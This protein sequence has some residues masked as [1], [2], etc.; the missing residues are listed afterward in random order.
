MLFC[1]FV[2][3]FKTV[4]PINVVLSAIGFTLFISW[5]L[6]IEYLVL[7]IPIFKK[8]YDEEMGLW[9]FSFKKLIVYFIIWII[10]ISPILAIYL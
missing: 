3:V 4:S 10:S 1:Y 7:L 6:L 9:K 5:S 8:W 2:G